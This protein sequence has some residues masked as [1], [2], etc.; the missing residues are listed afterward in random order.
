M[1][2]PYRP[3][4]QAWPVASGSPRVRRGSGTSSLSRRGAPPASSPIGRRSMNAFRTLALAAVLA[5]AAAKAGAQGTCEINT[6]G[7]PELNGARQYFTNA[8]KSSGAA[9]EKPKHLA[10]GVRVLSSDKALK[11]KNQLG[12]NWLMSKI[13]FQWIQQPK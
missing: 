2:R 11:D 7:S 10:N 6:G 4:R 8:A 3:A 13:L 12:R 9:A 1:A 5:G